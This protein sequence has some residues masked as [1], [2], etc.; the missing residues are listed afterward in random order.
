[1]VKLL[2]WQDSEAV[3]RTCLDRD[4][5]QIAARPDKNAESI[6]STF[7]ASAVS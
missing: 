3:S 6:L 7:P 5:A 4:T 1:M 2:N